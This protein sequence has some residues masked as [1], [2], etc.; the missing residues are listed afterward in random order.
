MMK[1]RTEVLCMLDD[2]IRAINENLTAGEFLRLTARAE[3]LM[4]VLGTD[5]PAYHRKMLESWKRSV[6]FRHLFPISDG[7][8]K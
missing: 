1:V 3:T 6:R 8:R 7:Q 4:E 5:T 2:T